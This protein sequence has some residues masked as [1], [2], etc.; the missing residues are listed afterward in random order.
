[1]VLSENLFF[2]IHVMRECDSGS[3]AVSDAD[4]GTEERQSEEGEGE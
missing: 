3:D 1:M 4:T 2:F